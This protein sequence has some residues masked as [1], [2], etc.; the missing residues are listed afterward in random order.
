MSKEGKYFEIEENEELALGFLKAF[1]NS[2]IGYGDVDIEGLS[3]DEAAAKINEYIQD[4]INS[5]KDINLVIDHKGTLLQEARRLVAE[6]KDNLALV[7]YATWWE[8]WINGVLEARLYRKDIIGKEFKQV[9]TSLNNRAKTTW[10]P[11]LIELPPFE[12]D[13]LDVMTKLADKR[14]GFVHYKYPVNNDDTDDLTEFFKQVE[15]SILYFIE[16]EN[17]NIFQSKPNFEI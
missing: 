14:N 4:F 17:T 11:K 7:T 1:V 12:K 2:A 10:F 13:H 5:G 6:K 9:I 16:Y 3:D 15:C 8:H